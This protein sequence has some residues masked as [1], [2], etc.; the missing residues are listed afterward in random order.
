MSDVAV[1]M[2]VAL[3]PGGVV[4]GVIAAVAWAT[5]REDRRYTLVREP[6]DQISRRA[7][8]SPASAAE[9][10]MPVLPDR[11]RTGAP[12]ALTGADQHF[13][14][15]QRRGPRPADGGEATVPPRRARELAAMTPQ[16]VAYRLP[17]GTACG[18]PGRAAGRAEP[19]PPPGRLRFWGCGAIG[20]LG[21]GR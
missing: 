5:H 18:A 12:A 14:G 4:T 3:I 16:P 6:P 7:A 9:A 19:G 17:P 20:R 1:V 8:G 10:W 11:T 15:Y 2:A 21:A 13:S